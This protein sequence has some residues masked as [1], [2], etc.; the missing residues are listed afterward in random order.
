MHIQMAKELGMNPKKFGELANYRQERWK[1]PLPQFIE[2]IYFKHF[3]KERPDVV[4]SIEQMVK[5]K[6][7]K[8]EE[9]K[10][11]N[12]IMKENCISTLSSG[13]YLAP[14]GARQDR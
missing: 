11:R 1:V 12:E 10:K 2:R 4:T 8:N 3:K 14:N 5:D 6:K 13:P 9:R 7:K